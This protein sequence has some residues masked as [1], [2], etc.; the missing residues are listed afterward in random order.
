MYVLPL[1]VWESLQEKP[2]FDVDRE[3]CLKWFAKLV[4]DEPDIEP[5]TA[6]KIFIENVHKIP[7]HLLT[8]S[9]FRL[10]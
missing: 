3:A 1:Q 4:S 5:E 8:D 10:F 9:G 7:P 6:R 2:A